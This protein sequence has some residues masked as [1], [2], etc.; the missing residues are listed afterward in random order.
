MSAR[1]SWAAPALPAGPRSALIIATTGYDDESLRQLRSPGRDAGELAAVLGDAAV[2]GFAVTPVLN[3]TGAEIRLAIED[4]TTGCKPADQVLVYLSC[5]GLLDARGR[6]CFGGTD[7]RRDRVSA[8]GVG[9][10]WLFERLDECRATRQIVI[11]DC[12]FSGAFATD[13]K[14]ADDVGLDHFQGR[15]RVVLTASRATE[16]AFEGTT[17]HDTL[18]GG[19]VFTEALVHGLRSGAADTDEDGL[20]TVTE[21][22]GFA[23]ARVRAAGA[24][25]TPQLWSF[26]TEGNIVLARNPAGMTVTP[27]LLPDNVRVALVDPH[28]SIRIGA[29]EALGEWLSHDAPSEVV[30]ARQALQRVVQHDI[31]RVGDVAHAL[32]DPAD[33]TPSDVDAARRAAEAI[34]AEAEATR[35]LAVED[36][37][38]I[39]EQARKDAFG[40]QEHAVGDAMAIIDDAESRAASTRRAAVEEARREAEAIREAARADASGIRDEAAG[41]AATVVETTVADARREAEAI[42][43]A[44]RAEAYAIN[45]NAAAEAAAIIAGARDAAARTQRR[46][47]VG[48]A[49]TAGVRADEGPTWFA[50]VRATLAKL[51]ETDSP[52]PVAAR[53]PKVGAKPVRKAAKR[54]T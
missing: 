21:A 43:G 22:Y 1:Q 24:G 54:P 20:V 36:A 19:S 35:R 11:L 48:R 46:T 26:G 14:S 49:P 37:A 30:A 33:S 5:H 40:I 18:P 10:T 32:L 44:A 2:G 16:Y 52:P 25:Q 53:A 7:V 51:G 38:G 12:C 27:A 4:F 45:Q 41:K 39:R 9:A 6:L 13:R 47:G 42:R 31:P 17:A 23:Y 15:G 8:T 28:P 3:R 50:R 34:V 29:V